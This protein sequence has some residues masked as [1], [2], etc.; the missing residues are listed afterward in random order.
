MTNIALNQMF[1]KFQNITMAHGNLQNGV[2]WLQVKTVM[3]TSTKPYN[4]ILKLSGKYTS[5]FSFSFFKWNSLPGDF[6]NMLQC[7]SNF[8]KVL[9]LSPWILKVWYSLC[10]E[11]N[12]T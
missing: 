10:S 8:G 3:F 5:F 7:K 9:T 4:F 12:L 6:L 1:V 11:V 2:L